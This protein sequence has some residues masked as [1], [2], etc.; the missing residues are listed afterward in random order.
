MRVLLFNLLFWSL[1]TGSV[2]CK[3]TQSDQEIIPASFPGGNLEL[4]K[5]MK[6]NMQWQQG[7]LTVAGKVFVSFIIDAKGI[8]SDV[9]V[10]R[11]L[12]ETCDKEAI[13]LIKEMPQWNPAT[14]NGKKIA[15][16]KT[17]PIQFDL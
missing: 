6:E 10:I 14:K 5:Y 17:I 16:E 9:R 8:I 13:R 4:V 1:I 2:S 11:E 7:Q 12:C 15:S 3:N